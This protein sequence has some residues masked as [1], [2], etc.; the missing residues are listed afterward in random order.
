MDLFNPM[1]DANLMNLYDIDCMC[2]MYPSGTD[3]GCLKIGQK[4][5]DF[6]TLS[7]FG[8]VCLSDYKGKWLIFFSH[9]AD[10][11]PVCTTE[12]VAFAKE[13][14]EFANR[15][16]C[17]LGVSIDSNPSHLAWVENIKRTQ[18]VIIPFPI[19]ADRNA[20]IAKMYGMFSIDEESYSTVRNVFIIDPDGII[21]A[22]LI[23][24]M[25]NGRYIP[26]ILR[27]LD[28]LQLSTK[29]KVVTPANWL[30]GDPVMVP[31]PQTYEEMMKRKDDAGLSC[32]DWY[33]CYKK[34]QGGKE[35]SNLPPSP[36][37]NDKY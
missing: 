26:E 1:D 12:F 31:P 16:A 5:P 25:T 10:F 37:E 15:N 19:L 33:L 30:P 6:C 3:G 24:P 21:R 4:A 14:P 28:A 36:L 18:G 32:V 7:T 22:M 8:R 11:T 35:N 27:L 17:L 20:S 13:A 2:N 34:G 9:P 23:Y 29:E